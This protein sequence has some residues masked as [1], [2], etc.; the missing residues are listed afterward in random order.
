[1]VDTQ[2]PVIIN[3]SLDPG[4]YNASIPAEYWIVADT[5]SG[6]L[7]YVHPTGWQPGLVPAVSSYRFLPLTSVQILN[8]ILPAG[9][10]TITFGT[11]GLRDKVF[12]QTWTDSVEVTVRDE[13]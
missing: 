13:E 2:S 12:D 9:T 4:S 11:D 8:Q 3:I 5:P 6:L 7:S 1:M 10:Y